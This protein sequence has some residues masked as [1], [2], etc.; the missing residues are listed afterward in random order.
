MLDK[1]EYQNR[2]LHWLRRYFENCR[3]LGKAGTA[4]YE[5]TGEIHEGEGRA[6]RNVKELPGLPY[7]CLRLPTGG[8]KTLVACHA[9]GVANRHLLQAENSLVIWLVP[10][11]AI[12]EQTLK[13]LRNREH[14]YRQA[15]EAE[16]GSV[17]VMDI[18]EA[19]YVT[20]P[21]LDS[22]T[23]IVVATMQAFRRED[24]EG[25]KVFQSNGHL[26]S[27]FQGIPDEIL[28]DVERNADGTF[29]YS[30][31]TCSASASRW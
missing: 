18:G 30:S 25:L 17:A 8:G 22:Q 11:Q 19:L 23:V 7:I 12:R 10:S 13:A 27:H 28:R 9:V 3:K 5:T 6:Y 14:P 20:K 15:L 2:A 16:L 26:M 21:A 31:P 29:D 4:F 1:K 24:T